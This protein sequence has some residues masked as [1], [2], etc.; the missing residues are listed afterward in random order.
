MPPDLHRSSSCMTHTSIEIN[1]L[2]SM[3][4]NTM[5]TSY[6]ADWD[7]HAKIGATWNNSAEISASCNQYAT[8]SCS[9]QNEDAGCLL[10]VFQWTE[11]KIISY[12]LITR[13]VNSLPARIMKVVK[14]ALP[15]IW[16]YP[17]YKKVCWF[18]EELQVG[19]SRRNFEKE[20]YSCAM[21]LLGTLN[22]FCKGSTQS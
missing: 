16:A 2:R 4:H 8:I 10:C 7:Q 17:H 12:C 6:N 21:T 15:L 14:V 20:L 3:L 1:M 13:H 18:K 9:T 11:V 22:S 19:T 5:H